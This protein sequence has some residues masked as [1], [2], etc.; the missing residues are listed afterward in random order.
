MIHNKIKFLMLLSALLF[1][2]SFF[3]QVFYSIK[4]PDEKNQ[5]FFY[6]DKG[7]I[8]YSLTSEKSEII[9]KSNLGFEFENMPE[10]RDNFK[11]LSISE[12]SEFDKWDMVWGEQKTI[13]N[14]NNS[15]KIQLQEKKGQKRK[16]NLYFKAFNDGIGFRYEIPKQAHISE[17][18]ITKELTEFNF[19]SDNEIWWQPADVD[20]YEHFYY[21]TKVSEVDAEKT[22]YRGRD[23]RTVVNR[24]AVNTPATFKTPKGKYFA[25]HEAALVDYTDMTLGVKNGYEMYADLVSGLNG[26]KVITK[27]PMKTPWRVIILANSPGELI[28]SKIVLNLNEPNKLKDTSFIKPMVYT[29]IWW[30]MHIDKG[31]WSYY[32][33]PSKHSANTQNAFK[34]IDF[35]A[36]HKIPG[37]LIEG[38]NKGWDDWGKKEKDYFNFTEAFPDFD[39]KKIVEYAKSKGV[40]IIGHHETAG[41]VPNYERQLDAAF[42]YYKDLGISAVKTGYAGKYIPSGER[43]HSQYGVNHNNL[44]MRKTAEYGLMLDAHEPIKDTGLRRTYPNFM[45]REGVR[46]EEFQAWGGGNPPEHTLNLPFTRGLAGPM[47]YTPG[48]FKMRFEN[49]PDQFVQSTLTKELALMVLLYSPLQM[50]ADIPE[51]YENNPAFDFVE[52]FK[53][54]YEFSK[55]INAE[56][57]KYLTIARKDRN[58]DTWFLG[59]AT[60][61]EARNFKIKLDF[62]TPGKNYEMKVFEDA[63]EGNWKTNPEVYN[64]YTKIVSSK[65]TLELNLAPGGGTA[66]YFKM[67]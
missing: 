20:S 14:H 9:K 21:H 37:L 5:V 13:T 18:K 23:D 52:N 58:S 8:Y 10:M 53:T 54:D 67:K 56:I 50:A 33:N 65:D 44:V 15:L 39:I 55:V 59:S 38:W 66:V 60:N 4:S 3:A 34:Y 2:T 48:I 64:I 24:F 19:S 47:D 31:T 51:N 57:G 28:D 29:G 62:L 45:T 7:R 35:N 26:L 11:I 25:I 16:L 49:R 36:K 1:S 42:Q 61:E 41:D 63:K 27:A 6:L 40:E 46:G 43:S 17:I 22:D 32:S 30:E 12:F